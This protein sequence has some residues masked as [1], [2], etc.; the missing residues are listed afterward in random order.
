MSRGRTAR[1]LLPFGTTI[2]SEM[3]ALAVEHGAINLAQGFPDFE[4][5]PEIVDAAVAAL[6]DGHNQYQRSMGHPV[7]VEAV[8]DRIADLYGLRY[9]PMTEVTITCGATEAIAASML[10]LVNPGDEVILFEPYYDS[11]PATVA[12]AGGNPRFCGLR[13]PDFALDEDELG[14]LFGPRTR[15]LVLNTPH[16]PTGKVFERDELEYIAGLCAHHGVVVL[17]DEVYEHLTFD[18][19]EHV[20]I[21]CIDGMREQTLTVSSLG[22]TYSFT[23]WKTGWVTGPIDLV[24]AVQAAHQ[25][26]TFCTPGPLQLAAAVALREH[27]RRYTAALRREYAERRDR[28]VAALAGVGFQVTPPAGTYFVMAGF[29]DLFDGDDR[30]FACFLTAEVGV[31]CIPPSVFYS[32]EPQ[33]ARQL[34]RFAFC[35][36]GGTLDAAAERLRAG[37]G[38]GSR[39]RAGAAAEAGG[40]DQAG[41]G[42]K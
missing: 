33:S 19:A 28:L 39:A 4:G 7:L 10:G 34:A 14:R 5:P 25:F 23:G 2:F 29:G 1:R 13:F 20:P 21:A 38:R 15:L 11:Y 24:A 3:T 27:G 41:S 30:E 9:D 37:L 18:G 31:A 35:K 12:L 17:A 32:E 40:S 6:R 16:N 36:R 22:K 26:L 8:A 42:A